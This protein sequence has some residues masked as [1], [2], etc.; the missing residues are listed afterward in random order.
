MLLAKLFSYENR[1][2]ENVIFHEGDE[3]TTFY[4][5]LHG[6]VKLTAKKGTEDV[7]IT[8]LVWSMFR[9]FFGEGGI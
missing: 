7:L 5:L 1:A 4:V 2:A 8:T 3:G 6:K 9:V